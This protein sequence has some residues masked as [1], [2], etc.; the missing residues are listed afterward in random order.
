MVE[1]TNLTKNFST[2]NNSRSQLPQE[3]KDLLEN[4]LLGTKRLIKKEQTNF[5]SNI[6]TSN[7]YKKRIFQSPA[8]IDFQETNNSTP[9][10]ASRISNRYLQFLD[11]NKDGKVSD[12]ESIDYI[13]QCSAQKINT[14]RGL[15]SINK[16]AKDFHEVTKAFDTA[17]QNGAF[18]DKEL[19]DALLA[20]KT[21]TYSNINYQNA[22][23][24]LKRNTRFDE[25]KTIVD[26]IDQN[27]N[28]VITDIEILD[29]VLSA[30]KGALDLNNEITQTILKKNTKFEKII[31]LLQN[32]NGDF[33]GEV[34]NKD[35]FN[36]L[37]SLK[38]GNLSED[39]ALMSL[40]LSKNSNRDNI[41]N[42]I[43]LLDKDSNG[44]LSNTEFGDFILDFRNGKIN[45]EKNLIVKNILES[46]NN[47]KNLLD[48]INAIDSDNNGVVSDEEV[49]DLSLAVKKGH[50]NLDTDLTQLILGKNENLKA[51][52]GLIGL[53]DKNVDG[54]IQSN[55][56]YETMI[57]LKK[58]EFREQDAQLINKIISQNP[59]KEQIQ[60]AINF[61]DIDQDGIVKDEEV[62]NAEILLRKGQ[63]ENIDRESLKTVFESNPKS[64]QLIETL[65]IFDPQN[66]GIVSQGDLINKILDKRKGL[67]L[68]PD[69]IIFEKVIRIFDKELQIQTA[70]N[71]FDSD[72]NG[73]IEDSSFA[74][75]ILA[76][77][78]GIINTNNEI[79]SAIASKNENSQII[80][81]A[82]SIMDSDNNGVVSAE[83]FNQN[84]KASVSVNGVVDFQRMS[85]ISNILNVVYPDAIKLDQF[86]DNIDI[87]NDQLLSDMELIDGLLNLR[88][89]SVPNP[90]I[91]IIRVVI[92][93][94]QNFQNIIKTIDKIDLEKDGVISNLDT[95]NGLVAVRKGEFTNDQLPFVQATLMKNANYNNIQS[96]LNLF[97]PDLNGDVSNWELINAIFKIRRNEINFLIDIQILD[98][99]KSFNPNK[100]KIE[101]LLKTIDPDVSGTIDYSELINGVL[102]INAGK[103]ER[104][105]NSVLFNLP[106]T[107]GQN[108][109]D[110]IL[111]AEL[112]INKIDQNRNGELSDNEIASLILSGKANGELLGFDPDFISAIFATN[113][114]SNE[115]KNLIQKIDSD[116]D[117]I[118][119]DKEI[120]ESVLAQKNG[121]LVASSNNLLDMIL[122]NNSEYSK[123]KNLVEQVD[124]DNNG[125]ISDTNLVTALFEFRAPAQ[126]PLDER[127]LEI[128]DL[129]LDTNHSKPYL[130]NS[131]DILALSSNG[132][133]VKMKNTLLELKS[134]EIDI[135]AIKNL[136]DPGSE[137]INAWD[138]QVKS[139]YSQKITELLTAV[140]SHSSNKNLSALGI[141]SLETFVTELNNLKTD[142]TNNKKS[143]FNKLHNLINNYQTTV[144]NLPSSSPDLVSGIFYEDFKG[145]LNTVKT[146][147][148]T[149]V[150]NGYESR[151]QEIAN[152]AIKF[153]KDKDG[154]FNDQEVLNG[155]LDI[156][157][158]KLSV[159]NPEFLKL[160]F[161]S[162]SNFGTINDFINNSDKDANGTI[163]KTEFL[164]LYNSTFQSN[165]T[166][167][168]NLLNLMGQY[169]D[170]QASFRTIKAFDVYGNA[171]YSDSAIL[172][173]LLH[174]R[175]NPNQSF[176]SE[177]INSIF[178]LNP[179]STG[180]QKLVNII[181][182]DS[183]GAYHNI[184]DVLNH[185]IK[186]WKGEIPRNN[187]AYDFNGDGVVN[188]KDASIL[189]DLHMN[190][191]NLYKFNIP[192]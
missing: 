134:A 96:A 141:P 74:R 90:G 87:N 155:I 38:A 55:E 82:I 125:N 64:N 177:I 91:D 105:E 92:S 186:I 163:S 172:Q 122:S 6:Q 138:T 158:N 88:N 58:G 191:N 70:L 101:E 167:N 162:N 89:G 63:A 133:K 182:P 15:F 152:L 184:N 23:K 159:S 139:V 72:K 57:A 97:D 60:N 149:G 39:Q 123:I 67:I 71:I 12:E 21:P 26:F 145:N 190:V 43:D 46:D 117:G 68:V 28:G 99:L 53:I 154:R 175:A 192:N 188:D 44:V 178:A 157:T 8:D 11:K 41:G 140:Q 33:N 143:A 49:I 180:I 94:N 75:G 189:F 153:D 69:D 116:N 185:A 183:N 17:I 66:T 32:T 37:I 13:L 181:D 110:S 18:S 85:I 50:I 19:T 80:Q 179:D 174:I 126:N 20:L 142:L 34:S 127:A 132:D 24:V 130:E 4:Y 27:A 109:G 79:I 76:S 187:L 56:V 22:L 84:F 120:I 102:A 1:N 144:T 61:V 118:F 100:N 7:R 51:L 137:V 148:D 146:F 25:I 81:T 136:V 93:A 161:N 131:Y 160:I 31:N 108:Y 176:D 3:Q 113:P 77:R 115:I 103:L 35:V 121:S 5:E 150:M 166:I 111:S 128:L 78:A 65:N 124:K 170:Y 171:Q 165:N 83:E 119:S 135:P 42:S 151:F 2:R 147:L 47:F 156:K 29:A 45:Q 9:H 59:K 36:I 104:P 16:N 112:L 169:E 164:T 48:V 168:K 14:V 52:I 107:S 95:L 73:I 10:F 62:L 129:I 106:N 114:R 30:K 40:F 54:N 86:R 173:G 98:A